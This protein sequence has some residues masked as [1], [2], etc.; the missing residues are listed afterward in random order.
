MGEELGGRVCSSVNSHLPILGERLLR[1]VAAQERERERDVAHS[2]E[3]A[4]LL[5]VSL[6]VHQHHLHLPLFLHLQRKETEGG[7]RKSLSLSLSTLTNV[8]NEVTSKVEVVLYVDKK[9]RHSSTG[10]LQHTM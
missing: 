6:E 2:S 1:V 4:P 9:N 5:S 10:M 7:R 3:G 8:A